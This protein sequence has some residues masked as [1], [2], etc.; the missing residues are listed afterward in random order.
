MVSRS[1]CRVWAVLIIA[2]LAAATISAIFPRIVQAA[3]TD[4]S[5]GGYADRTS[6]AQGAP[7]IFYIATTSSPFDLQIVNEADDQQP[8]A[9]LQHLTSQPEDCTGH[10]EKGCGW[11]ATTTFIIPADW[12]SGYYAARFPTSHGDQNIIFVAMHR[13]G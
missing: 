9:I 1:L 10:Y 3:V 8:V 12:A 6:V 5:Q 11:A 2:V 13:R 4:Y 7:I